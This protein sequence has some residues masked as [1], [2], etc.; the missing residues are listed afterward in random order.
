MTTMMSA[1]GVLCSACPAYHADSK[2]AAYRQCTATAWHK[3]YRLNET[4]ADISCGGCLSSDDKL[5]HSSRTCQARRCCRAKGFKA[6]AECGVANCPDLEKAQSVW[7]DVPALAA[8]LSPE[9]FATYAQ[10][11][12]H[13]RQRLAQAR[14]KFFPQ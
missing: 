4:A 1:C 3:I 2:G 10:P 8:G 5:F 11:Y 9:D 14:R 6:C 13:H 7:D 12:C